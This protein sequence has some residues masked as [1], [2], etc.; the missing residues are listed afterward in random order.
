MT[1]QRFLKF[2]NPS[3]PTGKR[4]L[5]EVPKHSVLT[6]YGRLETRAA[7]GI[8]CRWLNSTQKNAYLYDLTGGEHDVRTQRIL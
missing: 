1:G 7:I 3:H 8:G 4:S 6:E 5:Y 2:S